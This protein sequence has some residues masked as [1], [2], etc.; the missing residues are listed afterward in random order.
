MLHRYRRSGSRQR[1][2]GQSLAEFA[3]VFPILML[4]IG[5]IIQFGVIFWGQN[6]LTQVARYGTMGIHTS[7]LSDERDR[8][9]DRQQHRGSVV[10]DRVHVLERKQSQCRAER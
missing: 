8:P 4:I 1:S 10:P 3:L 7:D 9:S 6:T 2:R 5:G